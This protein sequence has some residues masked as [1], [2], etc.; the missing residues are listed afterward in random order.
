NLI[1][2]AAHCVY[3][4]R[5]ATNI[6]FVP[7]YH[8]GQ[9]PVGGWAVATITVAAG[10]AHSHDHILDFALLGFPPPAGT[11]LPIQLV[12]GGLWL[13]INRGYAHPIEAIGY[14]N[15]GDAPIKCATHSVRFSPTQ[16]KFWCHDFQNGT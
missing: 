13:G 9:Q 6:E 2:T 1:L 5:Y 12:T 3:G 14:N 10:S 4:S 11:R 15:T 16:M 7:E 8:N